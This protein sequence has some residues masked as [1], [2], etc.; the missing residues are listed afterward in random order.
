MTRKIIH[1]D[2]DA[3][4]ASIEQLD[5][6][7][8]KGHPVAVGGRNQRGVVAAASYE[9]RAFGVHSA[10]PVQKALKKCPHLVVIPT[11]MERYKELS[12]Q[13]MNIFHDY[14][15]LVEPLSIDEA[16]LDVTYNKKQMPSATLIA[17]EIKKR[18]WY[19]TA[20]K[21]SAGVSYNKF[22]AKIASDEDKPDGLYV[23]TPEKAT[24]FLED[25]PIEKFFGIGAATATR[26]HN[27]NIF[28]GAD[29]KRKEQGWLHKHYGKS[30]LAYYQLVR[31]IDNR[32]VNPNRERKS[33]GAERTYGSNLTSDAEIESRIKELISEL[34]KRLQ[35]AHK[36]GR[37]LT[38]KVRYNSFETHTFSRTPG[39]LLTTE[40]D[41][42]PVAWQLLAEAKID[43]P[44]R[45]LGLTVSNLLTPKEQNLPIQLTIRF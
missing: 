6:P 36:K 20:L 23:I 40:K 5:N 13:I 11:R 32:P 41:F 3:F 12:R 24:V 30:G 17:R 19:E 37:T 39:I 28:T 33:V 29:L 15:D 18:I 2:M 34:D 21:A 27:D 43:Q 38:L 9:A 35:L 8:L 26:M 25:L 42:A 4:F 44:V 10:M 7:K 31:G 22:L 14:T 1:I 45:L 16:F